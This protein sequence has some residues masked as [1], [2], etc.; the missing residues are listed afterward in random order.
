MNMQTKS[1]KQPSEEWLRKM[2][3]LED[4]HASVSVGGMAHDLGMLHL[5]KMPPG[6]VF[7]QFIEFAR[8]KRH[9]TVEDLAIQAEID[10]PELVALERISNTQAS[11][12]TVRKLANFLNV[13]AEPLM[14]IAGVTTPKDESMSNAALQFAACLETTAELTPQED[15]AFEDFVKII[16]ETSSV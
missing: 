4:Q 14:K 13:P 12:Q 6:A 10:L 8:R 15:Q 9:L 11:R 3:N 1:T 7:G 2:A 5:T 16:V